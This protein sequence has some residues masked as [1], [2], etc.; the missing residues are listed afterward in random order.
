MASVTIADFC[1]ALYCAYV[2]HHEVDL[3]QKTVRLVAR[4]TSGGAVS[5]YDLRFEWGTSSPARRAPFA[6]PAA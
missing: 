3:R 1:A 2:E 5:R 4:V 6:P